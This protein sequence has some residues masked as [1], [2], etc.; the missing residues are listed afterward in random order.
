MTVPFYGLV[1]GLCP[2]YYG[3]ISISR[4]F[5][6]I[7][8]AGTRSHVIIDGGD[9]GK[10]GL[11][12]TFNKR[13]KSPKA[14]AAQKGNTS[15]KDELASSSSNG[16][17]AA[18]EDVDLSSVKGQVVED[19]KNAL[20]GNSAQTP[21]GRAKLKKSSNNK[22]QSQSSSISASPEAAD[23]PNSSK[24]LSA[25]KVSRKSKS[26]PSHV[27]PEVRCKFIFRV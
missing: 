25:A 19:N 18:V 20:V 17:A 16:K 10:N 15:S 13:R 6:K 1:S 4:P 21:K 11:V 7:A 3:S 9:S 26:K 24:K 27:S 2:T 22:I 5:S 23:T 8:K 12:N 14:V